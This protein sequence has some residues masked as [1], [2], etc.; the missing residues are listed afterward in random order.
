[1]WKVPTAF[2][3]LLAGCID[4]APA[5]PPELGES[6]ASLQV[7]GGSLQAAIDAAP[8]DAIIDICAGTY[9][10]HL[11][12]DGKRLELRGTSGAAVTIID[13]GGSGRALTVRNS[14]GAGV[15]LRDLTL[16]GGATSSSGGTIACRS[17]TLRV[18]DSVIRGGRATGG[19]GLGAQACALDIARSRFEGNDAGG[20]RGGG[21]LASYSTGI[22][23]ANTFTG[24]D[25]YE[26]GAVAIEHG[27][28]EVADNDVT[29]NTAHRGAGLFIGDDAPVHG[30]RIVDN[31]AG[32]T[33]GGVYVDARTGTFE[34][35]TIEG[36]TSVNDGGGVYVHKGAPV[37]VDNH[38]VRNYSGD[39]GGGVRVFES[40]ARLER[41]LVEDNEAADSGGGIRVS[42]LPATMIDNLVRA[43]RA[44]L[45]GG[46][47]LDN[48][49]SVL[50]GGEVTGNQ[51]IDGGGISAALWPWN[52]GT[53]AGV[54]ISDNIA[55]GRGGGIYLV[56]NY[57][58]V[59]L[60]DLVLHGNRAATGGGLYVGGTDHTL[61][62]SVLDGN[63][64]TGDGGGLYVA[65][66]GPSSTPRHEFLV[67][68]ANTAARGSA[69]RAVTAVSV[70]GS[71]LT[72]H[73]G[74]AVSV[75][76]AP[77]WRYND[78]VPR[79]FAGMA[80][81]TGASGNISADPL[82][83]SPT[84]G[85]VRLAAGSPAI[86]A[87]DPALRDVDGSR[88][89]MGRFGG[90]G[91][92]AGAPP[93]PPPPSVT[94]ALEADAY[95]AAATPTTGYGA[96][97]LLASDQS[98]LEESYLRFRVTGLTAPPAHARLRLLVTDP[99]SDGPAV[100]LADNA[101]SEAT[102]TWNDRPALTGPALADLGA[103][104]LGAVVEYDVT[105]AITGD[106]VYTFALVATSTSGFGV[107]SREG[108]TPPVLVLD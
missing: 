30:N 92:A 24:N 82:F 25:A 83:V 48:D 55:T 86:D 5:D 20:A 6:V 65:S 107:S 53:I 101:W 81:P 102:V 45:G 89:D 11:V 76:A 22:L 13:A 27:A 19:G 3:L 49:A 37:L 78:V 10:E 35:N 52:G 58:A 8:D 80:D 100:H 72:E 95:V 106:G 41:N 98:P 33:A 40:T 79:S 94:V 66:A 17:S 14:S 103:A 108:G 71:I 88:A 64:A 42:H 67:L 12:I 99:S 105:A 50:R 51:A 44:E 91:G 96:S 43:N 87:A 69:L 18:R 23:A 90:P 21:V 29:A 61:A 85:D 28:V 97:S 32:W 73:A 26:G 54:R 7:C 75:S 62:N 104:A 77:S 56:D 47:D 2:I 9:A 68:R 93:P 60:R 15:R 4:A 63:A 39:D 16:Q 59:A 84:T 36:N 1:M 74:T 46:L 70:T 34:G 57:K 38:V 31:D